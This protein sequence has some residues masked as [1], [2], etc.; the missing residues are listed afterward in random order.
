M[1][2]DPSSVKYMVKAEFSAEGVVERS[3]V[4]GAIFGQTEGLLGEELDLRDLQKSGRIGRIEVE[5]EYDQGK[6][7]GTIMI[8]SSMDQVETAILAAALETIERVGPC[9]A[10]IEVKNIEDVRVK[11]RQMI[12]ERAKELLAH[13]IEASK[14]TAK[15]IAEEVRGAVHS[16]E[17]ILYGPDKC[18]AGPEVEE[19]ESIIIVEGRSDVLNL[20][21]HGIRNAIAVEGTNVP[22]TIQ[23]L[24]KKKIAT[25][26]V[27]G[28][29]G[30]ELILKELLQVADID[31]V[32]RAPDNYEVEELTQKQIMKALRAKMPVEQFL[33]TYKIGETEKKESEKKEVKV[34]K[35]VEVAKKEVKKELKK[36]LSPVQKAL[37]DVFSKISGKSKALFLDG[38]NRVVGEKM[39]S[40]LRTMSPKDIKNAK[41]LVFDGIITQRVID[42]AYAMGLNNVLG[43]K[44]GTV[45]KIPTTI[46]IWTKHDLE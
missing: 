36:E 24:S 14:G 41:S 22:K 43:I 28:D 33:E 3:D 17:L 34:E 10:K 13:L 20:L 2:I 9:K 23:E 42:L 16:E 32:A 46:N 39:V 19:S 45:S 8:P 40:E 31:F 21:K 30:G 37:M 44:L 15:S 12:A 18:P 7:V 25:V 6:S 26:F 11:K 4:I 35:K 38:N 5:V 27:D 29:R 1:H